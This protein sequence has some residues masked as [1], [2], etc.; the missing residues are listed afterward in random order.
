MAGHS[1]WAGIK[2]KKALIDNKRGKI[3][4]KLSKAIIVAAKLAVSARRKSSR[5][6]TTFTRT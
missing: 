5:P 4:S 3:W 1:H 6:T 2:H